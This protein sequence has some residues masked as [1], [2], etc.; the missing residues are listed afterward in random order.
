MLIDSMI[1][2]NDHSN[3]LRQSMPYIGML[4]QQT[5]RQIH[6]ALSTVK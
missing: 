5:V 3:R 4:D 1:G 2:V 6:Q